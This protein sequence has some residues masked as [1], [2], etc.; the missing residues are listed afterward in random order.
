MGMPDY[1]ASM[2]ELD[3]NSVLLAPAVIEV[4]KAFAQS[5]PWRGSIEE[6]KD[7]FLRLNNALAT[8]LCLPAPHLIFAM[9]ERVDSARSAYIPAL[10]TIII[11][12]RLSA[13]T[14]LHEWGHKLVGRSERE[15]CK[16]SL[17]LFRRCFPLSWSRL[18]FNGHM[19]VA[20]PIATSPEP[21]QTP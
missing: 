8:A 10:D 20:R 21:P 11:R 14:F 6:R 16:W 19:A 1:P 12:G 17:A 4:V 15:A 9:D 7:K 2:D 3:L 18:T 5:R 13:I